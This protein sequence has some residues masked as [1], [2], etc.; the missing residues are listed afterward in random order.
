MLKKKRQEG[1]GGELNQHMAKEYVQRAN[2][3]TQKCAR[4][5]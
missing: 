2:K 3:H 1:R 4:H 5:H